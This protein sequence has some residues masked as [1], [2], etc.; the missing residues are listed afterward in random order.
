MEH[1]TETAP[2]LEAFFAWAEATVAKLSAK[3]ALATAFRYT[4]TRREALSRFVTDGRLEVDNNIAENAMRAIATPASSW[5]PSFNIW[6]HRELNAGIDATRAPFTPAASTTD[7]ASRSV[8][9]I[10]NGA[11]GTTCSARRIPALISLRSRWLVTLRRAA[12]SRKVSQAPSFSRTC[13]R[14]CRGHA[15][16]NQP[17]APSGLVLSGWQAHPVQRGC[18]VLVGPAGGHAPND[19]QGVVGKGWTRAHPH[20]VCAAEVR[21]VVPLSN[22]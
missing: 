14:G 1:R 2:L 20:G 16:S 22:G 18:D 10:R 7:G 19:R 11:P 13:R 12:A 15:G 17:G 9:R 4:I 6:K 5:T 21:S 8:A 3:S